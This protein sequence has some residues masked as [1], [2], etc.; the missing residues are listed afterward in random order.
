MEIRDRYLGRGNNGTFPV[1]WEDEEFSF[2]RE[3]T[4]LFTFPVIWEDETIGHFILLLMIYLPI[5]WKMKHFK[6]VQCLWVIRHLSLLTCVEQLD[7]S[8]YFE[9]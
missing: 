6:I 3:D 1:I 4:T 9:R 2:T 7:L 5:L 8:H